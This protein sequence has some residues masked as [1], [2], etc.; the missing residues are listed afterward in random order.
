M[1]SFD[2]SKLSIIKRLPQSI[3]DSTKKDLID[4]VYG[5]IDYLVKKIF[6]S[7]KHSPN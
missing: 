7:I 2:A 1:E 5:L 4:W 3:I 6:Q